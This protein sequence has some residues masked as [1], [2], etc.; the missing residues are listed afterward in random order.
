MSY[1]DIMCRIE[2]MVGD[3]FDAGWKAGRA[4]VEDTETW[5]DG[6]ENGWMHAAAEA[7]REHDVDYCDGFLTAWNANAATKTYCENVGDA[8]HFECARCGATA[9]QGVQLGADVVKFKHCPNC[10][11]EVTACGI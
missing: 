1:D 7:S 9:M 4:S 2:E 10:G 3:L 5:H 8:W 11:S 6:Y